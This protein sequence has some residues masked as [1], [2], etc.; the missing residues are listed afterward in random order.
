MNH[1]NSNKTIHSGNKH[2]SINNHFRCKSTDNSNKKTQSRC[3]DEK[4]RPIHTYA[5]HK[6]L[7]SALETHTLKGRAGERY[8]VKMEIQRK[9]R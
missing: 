3:T 9:P 5:A 7:T 1:N 8:S 6:R 2:T 4:T